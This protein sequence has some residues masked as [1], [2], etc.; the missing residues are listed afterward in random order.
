MLFRFASF[1]L[2]FLGLFYAASGQRLPIG[3]WRSHLPYNSSTTIAMAGTKIYSGDPNSLFSYDTVSKSTKK[4]SKIDGL[5]QPNIAELGYSNETQTLVLAYSNSQIDLITDNTIYTVNDILNAK[6][7]G[8]KQ[9]NHLYFSGVHVFISTDF[10]LVVYNLQ[11]R[12]VTEVYSNF[13]S[14]S[15]QIQV[16]SSTISNDSLYVA[17][18]TGL[19]KAWN[20]PSANK[21]DYRNWTQLYPPYLTDPILYL[22]AYNGKVYAARPYYFIEYNNGSWQTPSIA[23]IISSQNFSNLVVSN[24]KLWFLTPNAI[25]YYDQDAIAVLDSS[26]NLPQPMDLIQT[27]QNDIWVADNTLGLMSNKGGLGFSPIRL[28]GP[29]QTG[30]F[31]LNSFE[32]KI[33]MTAGGYSNG[34]VMLSKPGAFSIFQDGLWQNYS[35]SL[36]NTP[37]WQDVVSCAYNPINKKVYFPSYGWGLMEW[38]Q[39]NTFKLFNNKTPGCPLNTCNLFDDCYTDYPNPSGN[40]N[41]CRVLDVAVDNAGKVWVLNQQDNFNSLTPGVVFSYSLDSTWQ[42]FKWTG[43]DPWGSTDFTSNNNV[44]W[45]QKILVDKHNTKWITSRYVGLMA[46]N[47]SVASMPRY[48]HYE[49]Y[50]INEICGTKV[51]DLTEDLDGAIWIGTENGICYFSD[52]M[53]VFQRTAVAASLPVYE[54]RALLSGIQIN[55][56]EIDGGNRK[57]VGTNNSGA[58]LFSS[59]GTSMVLHFD[60]TNSPLPSDVILDIEIDNKTGEVFFST[61]KGVISYQSDGT[62]GSDESNGSAAFAYPNPVTHDFTGSVGISGLANNAVVKITD[63]S[64]QLIYQTKAQGTLASW[65]VKDYTG[66]RAQPGVYLIFSSKDDGTQAVVTKIAV[67]D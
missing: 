40:G 14:A 4:L 18:S 34:Y 8:S 43:T 63:I 1:F 67:L 59:D 32:D 2:G 57:W 5:S 58:W 38:D 47:E 37:V 22:A 13:T 31:S 16:F 44:H 24:N 66:R 53:Q 55:A 46:F 26:Q 45:P 12:E 29:S 27:S 65:N 3:S 49:K 54:N 36:G 42:V 9:I 33:V 7:S 28:N 51:Y 56:I 60:H 41:Y 52:P 64:G 62:S 19:F 21:L 23:Q 35:N 48:L 61:D 30:A 39:K 11:K 50:S 20:N 17:T 6:V 10:G 15:N 25:Y